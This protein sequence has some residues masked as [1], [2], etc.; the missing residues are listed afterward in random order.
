MAHTL[1]FGFDEQLARWACD[2]IPWAEYSP[3]MKA[4]AWRTALM[5]PI[6]A[7]SGLHLPQLHPDQ[8]D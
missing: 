5:L 1:L 7:P 4:V 3:T 8:D 2:R 6:Q